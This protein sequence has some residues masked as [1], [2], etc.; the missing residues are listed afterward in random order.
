MAT[1]Q[2]LSPSQTGAS[3]VTLETA[4]YNRVMVMAVGLTAAETVTIKVLAGETEL[5]TVNSGGVATLTLTATTPTA[6]MGGGPTLRLSKGATAGAS[7]IWF[8]PSNHPGT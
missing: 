2:Q 1:A 5:D 3:T 4:N 7:S 8:A 6:W